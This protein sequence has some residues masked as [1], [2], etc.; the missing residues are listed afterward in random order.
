MCH[1]SDTVSC[2]HPGRRFMMLVSQTFLM[3]TY[4]LALCEKLFIG[5]CFKTKFPFLHWI[6]G[7]FYGKKIKFKEAKWY[8]VY[9]YLLPVTTLKNVSW[10]VY[11]YI[12][13]APY[14]QL[15]DLYCIGPE[16]KLE[17][18]VKSVCSCL[19]WESAPVSIPNAVVGNGTLGSDCV[20][21]TVMPMAGPCLDWLRGPL[22]PV[23]VQCS[24]SHIVSTWGE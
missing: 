22:S 15:E 21:R 3:S 7:K 24:A 20:M 18:V 23:P 19:D 16:N 12:L 10:D 11:K 17:K 5:K 2:K 6:R 8:T 1:R 13:E 14:Q 9:V 4:Y